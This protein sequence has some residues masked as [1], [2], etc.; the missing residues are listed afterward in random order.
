MNQQFVVSNEFFTFTKLVEFYFGSS[1]KR[2][3]YFVY[4]TASLFVLV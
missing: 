2:N 1:V 4:P 3:I